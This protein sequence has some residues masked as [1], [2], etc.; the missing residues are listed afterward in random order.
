MCIRD[1]YLKYFLF[2]I[3]LII[4]SCQNDESVEGTTNQSSSALFIEKN[5]TSTNLTFS[6]NLNPDTTNN[7]LEYLYY[8]NGGGI[9]IG[10]INQDGLEDILLT[11][12]E[13][14]DKLFLNQ[15]GL[16]FKDVTDKSGLIAMT[17]WSTGASMDDVNGDGLLD[18][19]ICK[20][21]PLS[22]EATHNLLYINNGDATFTESAKKY[23]LDFSGYSTQASFF[24]YDLDGDLDMYLLNQSVHSVRSYGK[25]S[26]RK[27]KDELA[28][29]RL[30]ENKLNEAA[31]R[32]VD[33]TEQ[34]GIYSSALGY[35]LAIITN[36]LNNDGLPD[37]YVGNDCL[38]YTSPSPRDAT[39]SRMP[40]SA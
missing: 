7:I 13:S 8:Y 32:F 6:N 31:G 16:Q 30:F 17:N 28:G 14:A 9:A 3:L 36:D 20:V 27:E 10:D 2:A 34:A 1:R 18:I 5:S 21:A 4:A 19:Y 25:I 35:G 40:S 22:G 24:D 29:D 37:I 15:G 33:V 11:A 26:R 23:G 12:N 39:L 38:L